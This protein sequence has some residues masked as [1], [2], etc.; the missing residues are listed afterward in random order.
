MGAERERQASAED[1]IARVLMDH[2]CG[3]GELIQPLGEYEAAEVAR[4]IIGVLEA[5]PKPGCG[6]HLGRQ[7]KH[8]ASSLC[9]ESL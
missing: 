4:K 2:F 1:R 3:D 7:S 5:L 8:D 9:Q 6:T